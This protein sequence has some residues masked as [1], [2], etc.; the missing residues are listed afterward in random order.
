MLTER[1]IDELGKIGPET[2]RLS[3]AITASG[4]LHVYASDYPRHITITPI[5]CRL[6]DT[7]LLVRALDLLQLPS[8]CML[9]ITAGSVWLSWH[10]GNAM[11]AHHER[12]HIW[13]NGD[14]LPRTSKPPVIEGVEVRFG[15]LEIPAQLY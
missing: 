11:F 9:C 8:R 6:D 3:I 10:G 5:R 7:T 1:A 13:I 15:W 12:T 4:E 2:S 14:P